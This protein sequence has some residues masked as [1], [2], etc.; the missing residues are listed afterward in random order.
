MTTEVKGEGL[1]RWRFASGDYIRSRDYT[2]KVQTGQQVMS[3]GEFT[4]EP[5]QGLQLAGCFAPRLS[6]LD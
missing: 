6:L 2:R 4:Q 1:Q 5:L 3:W